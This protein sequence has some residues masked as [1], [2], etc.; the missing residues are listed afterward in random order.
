LSLLIKNIYLFWSK[1]KY[2]FARTIHIKIIK[3][4]IPTIEI[5]KRSPK[6]EV[7]C[8]MLLKQGF[9][10]KAISKLKL[11]YER[12]ESDLKKTGDWENDSSERLQHV[13]YAHK[14][15]Q[16]IIPTKK[17]AIELGESVERQLDPSLVASMNQFSLLN[18]EVALN[19]ARTLLKRN[20]I[21]VLLKDS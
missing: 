7:L 8:Y 12:M 18:S 13:Q 4:L 17:D 14:V 21:L 10:R 1:N 15:C 11:K 16:K 2:Y 5:E 20:G 19:R 6:D 9:K 3:N